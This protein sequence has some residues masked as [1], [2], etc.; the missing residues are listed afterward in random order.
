MATRDELLAAAVTGPLWAAITAGGGTRLAAPRHAWFPAAYDGRWLMALPLPVGEHRPPGQPVA[1]LDGR[2]EF[3]RPADA[4]ALAAA[5]ARHPRSQVYED[6]GTG[7]AD[8]WHALTARHLGRLSASRL[9][10]ACSAFA[11]APGDESL[12]AHGDAWY[13]AIIQIDGAKTWQVGGSL[14]TGGPPA[15]RVTTRAGDILLLP[16]LVPHAVTTPPTPGRSLHLAFAIH[17]DQQLSGPAT[18]PAA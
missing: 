16:P 12:R 11:S 6:I 15:A 9:Q 10:V 2:D 1:L 3:E 7:A 18:P 4:K 14:L 17:R 8:T 13:G 5:S